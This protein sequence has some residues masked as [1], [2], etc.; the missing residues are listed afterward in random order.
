MKKYLTI[1]FMFF[2]A[3]MS[4]QKTYKLTNRYYVYNGQERPV[5]KHLKNPG[6]YFTTCN[7]ADVKKELCEWKRVSYF[8][9]KKKK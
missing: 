4:A 1:L 7:P 5:Y 6:W 3:T 9:T 2:C 8:K